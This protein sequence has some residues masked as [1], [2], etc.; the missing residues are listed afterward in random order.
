M[1]FGVHL[2]TAASRN[3]AILL[4]SQTAE[5]SSHRSCQSDHKVNFALMR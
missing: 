2:S 1:R 4:L 5:K 3:K